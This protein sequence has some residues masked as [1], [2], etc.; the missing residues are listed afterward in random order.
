MMKLVTIEA[1]QV[2]FLSNR[3]TNA[4][5]LST[6]QIYNQNGSSLYSVKIMTYR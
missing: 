6:I 5:Y 1:M 3:Y 4:C 2:T